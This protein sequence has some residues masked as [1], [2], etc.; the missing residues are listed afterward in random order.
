LIA[1]LPHCRLKSDEEISR[2]DKM[3]RGWSVCKCRGKESNGA[4]ARYL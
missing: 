1:A 2:S 4:A 3:A